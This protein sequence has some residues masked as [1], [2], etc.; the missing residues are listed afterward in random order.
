MSKR[1]SLARNTLRTDGDMPP[2]HVGLVG[3][4]KPQTRDHS[5]NPESPVEPNPPS[6]PPISQTLTCLLSYSEGWLRLTPDT[7]HKTLF[8]KF[9]WRR[10]TYS[11]HY[12]MS[13]VPPHELAY[14]LS[15]LLD[16]VRDTYAGLRKPTKDT[17]Y[18]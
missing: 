4:G 9:K 7:E 10:G 14:G 8:L 13:V 16:K 1:Y 6:N 5:Q 11:G 15:L 12:V 17:P 3:D 18:D 2:L